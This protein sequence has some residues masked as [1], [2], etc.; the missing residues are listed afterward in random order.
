LARTKR[1][2]DPRREHRITYEIIGDA[3][4]P[5]EQA[6]GWYYYLADRLDFP[7]TVTCIMERTI[8]PLRKGDEASVVGM[9]P[10]EECVREMFVLIR[11]D[12]RTLG[13]PLAQLRPVRP[14]DQQTGR[15]IDDWHYWVR[16]GY[17]F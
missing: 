13:V 14:V 17:E 10:E 1:T 12:D 9:A 15:A 11:W 6:M 8:S 16:M 4:G 2:R 5:E 3:Y 7:F